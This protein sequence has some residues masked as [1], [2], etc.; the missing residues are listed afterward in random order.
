[1]SRRDCVPQFIIGGAPRSGTTFLCHVLDNHPAI[2][3]AKPYIP[4]PKVFMRPEEPSDT[5]LDRYLAL[6]ANVSE[7]SL[8]G[9]K[10]SYYLES[11]S[12]CR[13][14]HETLPEVKLLFMV[15]E[16]V[17][18][19]YSNYLWSRKN[20]IETLPFERAVELEGQRPDPMPPEKSYARPFDYLSRGNYALFAESYYEKFSRDQVR[21]FLYEDI[22]RRPRELLREIQLFLQVEPLVLDMDRSELIN[23]ARDSGPQLDS[24]TRRKLRQGMLPSVL[25]FGEISGLDIS[26]WGYGS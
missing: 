20:G 4:E 6:F 12:I 24:R 18:R 14:I 13:K 25:R 8:L 1:M 9:E 3:L 16:P 2:Y 7:G 11:Q 15:R 19:A 26:A 5:Y 23:S 10:T 21:F 22:D 17:E